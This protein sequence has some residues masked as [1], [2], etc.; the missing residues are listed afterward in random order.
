MERRQLEHDDY[1]GSKNRPSDD[2]Y[3]HLGP[4][5]EIKTR[6]MILGLVSSPPHLTG[7]AKGQVGG[8]GS[9]RPQWLRFADIYPFLHRSHQ[10]I[11]QGSATWLPPPLGGPRRTEHTPFQGL[12]SLRL[13]QLTALGSHLPLL[14]KGLRSIVPSTF[15]GGCHIAGAQ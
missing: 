13:C 7:R 10:L 12:V 8:C 2:E 3:P 5:S 9:P 15:T 1:F 11:F 14:L 6:P 4:R